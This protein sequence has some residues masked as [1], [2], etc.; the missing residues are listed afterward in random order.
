M[1]HV[2]GRTMIGI[3]GSMWTREMPI[4]VLPDTIWYFQVLNRVLYL[5]QSEAPK[6]VLGSTFFLRVCLNGS[7]C[8]PTCHGLAS[9]C[10]PFYCAHCWPVVDHCSEEGYGLD[11]LA[12]WLAEGSNNWTVDFALG[13]IM[14]QTGWCIDRWAAEQVDMLAQ[15]ITDND[16]L[17]DNINWQCW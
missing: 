14:T 12:R 11:C 7:S 13:N 6:K 9:S 5:W 3:L 2:S 17:S 16:R 8:K 10:W 4:M 1:V 15:T